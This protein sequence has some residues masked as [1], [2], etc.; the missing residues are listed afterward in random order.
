LTD[1][2]LKN[3]QKL[4][5]DIAAI[6][7]LFLSQGH[8]DHVGGLLDFLEHNKKA[9]VVLSGKALSQKYYSKRKSLRDISPSLNVIDYLHRFIFVPSNTRIEDDIEVIADIQHIYPLPK[10]NKYLFKDTSYIGLQEDDFK[11]ELVFCFGKEKQ[12]VCTG[13]AHNGLLNML[14][15]VKTTS[16]SIKW[17]IGGFHLLDSDDIHQYE[18]PE[19]IKEIAV[20][21]KNE[22]PDTTF[23]TGHCTGDKVMEGFKDILNKQVHSFYVG[24]HE[25]LN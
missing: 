1:A 7:Y 23:Y 9:R 12:L 18:S 4:G 17:V 14:E 24:M 2:F 21:L 19:E 25:K 6:D 13:C 5:V 11:H 16:P 20:T 15:A 3:A 22:Y 10:A 8:V